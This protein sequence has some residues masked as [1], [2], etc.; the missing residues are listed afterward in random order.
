MH[1]Q[2]MLIN[3]CMAPCMA[4]SQR[5]INKGNTLSRK[6]METFAGLL[7]RAHESQGLDPGKKNVLGR[8]RARMD[9][10]GLPFRQMRIPVRALDDLRALLIGEGYGEKN[11]DQILK[12]LGS[13]GSSKPIRVADL[14]GA[15]SGMHPSPGHPGR[16]LEVETSAIP[17]VASLLGLF[18]LESQQ[19][20]WILDGSRTERED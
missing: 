13:P 11:I 2:K 5:S 1:D 6:G 4:P 19:I 7:F 16:D 18:G 3:L 8:F 17:D 20:Q 10:S 14:F 15:F 12:K 9:V